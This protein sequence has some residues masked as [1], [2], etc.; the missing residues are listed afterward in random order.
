V[1]RHRRATPPAAADSALS[2]LLSKLRRALGDG[3]LT[4]RG[5]LRLNLEPQPQLAAPGQHA[6]AQRAAQLR[7]QRA[8]R[9]LG[10]RRRALGPQH[11]DQL[12]ARAA[13][14][15]V[16]HQVGEQETAL[17]AG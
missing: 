14:R 4:G 3:V 7:E 13:A 1:L 10:R 11:V 2:A 16:D 8:E 15:P 6:V 17:P 5:E 12:V 9:R